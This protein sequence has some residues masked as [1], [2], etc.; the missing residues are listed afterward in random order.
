MVIG[1]WN[2]KAQLL[3]LPRC[4]P[5]QGDLDRNIKLRC[6]RELQSVRD[7]SVFDPEADEVVPALSLQVCKVIA[8]LI[9]PV[10]QKDNRAGNRRA[11]HHD[12]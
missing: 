4:L 9:P 3:Q 5:A 10:C 7:G 1:G 12:T 11:V 6:I 8:G 2:H